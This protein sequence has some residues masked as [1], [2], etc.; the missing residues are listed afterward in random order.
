MFFNSSSSIQGAGNVTF[1]AGT[2][3]INGLFNVTGN[4]QSSGGATVINFSIL[5]N[6]A[7]ATASITSASGRSLGRPLI[8][9]GTLTHS[10]A[11]TVQMTGATL[12]IGGTGLNDFTNDGS[13]TDASGTH[14]VVNSGTIRK[15]GG[16]G[17]S[18]LSVPLKTAGTVQASSGTLNVTGSVS[19]FSGGT[20]SGGTW[21]LSG[22][23]ILLPGTTV[24][25]TNQGSLDLTSTSSSSNE[26]NQISSNSGFLNV[27]N[28]SGLV[29]TGNLS[30]SGTTTI[31]S[32]STLGI[33]ATSTTNL[34]SQWHAEGNAF[35]AIDSNLATLIKVAGYSIYRQLECWPVILDHA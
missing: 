17:T 11:S 27:Q 7:V 30:N 2:T 9:N 16:T 3:T 35:D 4:V 12:T 31:A 15:T 33:G 13:F 29:T 18:T 22:G 19:Q 20:L 26:F 10:S 6:I 1:T 24:V 14:S 21:T 23:S 25:S 8:L 32:S 5:S 28:G 34:V